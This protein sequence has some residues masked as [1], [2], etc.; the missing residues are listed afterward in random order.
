MLIKGAIF[1]MD[2][3]LVDSLM[4]W[5]ILWAEFGERYFSDSTYRPSADAD[6]AVRTMHFK[7]ATKYLHSKFGIGKNPEELYEL[8]NEIF[9]DFYT[10]KVKIKN[11]VLDFLEYLYQNNIKMCIASASEQRLVELAVKCCGL[12][13]YFS[14]VISCADIGKGKDVPDVFLLAREHL[15]TPLCETW[16]FED[17]YVA[18]TT[19]VNAGFRTVGVFDKYSYNQD[20]MKENSDIYIG[21]NEDMRKLIDILKI[22]KK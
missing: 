1:D 22:G 8:S 10:N 12:G 21:E 15:G 3:T 5:D 19:A 13:K 20:I 14:S 6:K 7:D 2:G 18:L 11:G 17:S 16:V 4:L 9:I